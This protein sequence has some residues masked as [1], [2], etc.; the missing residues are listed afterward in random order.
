MID[1]VMRYIIIRLLF[2]LRTEVSMLVE[3][4]VAMGLI[5]VCVFA[6]VTR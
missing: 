2:L 3:T 4:V 6:I 1:I 5:A